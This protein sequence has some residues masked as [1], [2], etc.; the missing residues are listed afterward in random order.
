[1]GLPLPLI[2][3]CRYCGTKILRSA[4][5]CG[6]ILIRGSRAGYNYRE[7]RGSTTAGRIPGGVRPC[8][9]VRA[10]GVGWEQA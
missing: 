3:P 6:T 2:P 4:E 1:M 9:L 8:R 10:V 7:E 5:Q